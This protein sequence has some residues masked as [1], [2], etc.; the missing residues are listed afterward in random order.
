MPI[1]MAGLKYSRILRQLLSSFAEP[2]WH[3][4]T[5]TR[6]KKSGLKSSEKCSTSSSPIS[7]W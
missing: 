5:M 6:S 7:Y 2:R 4:S 3:S 1:W